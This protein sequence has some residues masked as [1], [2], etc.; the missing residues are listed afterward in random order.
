MITQSDIMNKPPKEKSYLIRVP[1]DMYQAIQAIADVQRRS[2]TLQ[3]QILIGSAINRELV[4][5]TDIEGDK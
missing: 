3:A 1:A 2:I 5:P 4:L